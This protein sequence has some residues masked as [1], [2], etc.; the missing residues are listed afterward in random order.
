MVSVAGQAALRYGDCGQYAEDD[1]HD[2]QLDQAMPM[3]APSAS[4]RRTAA[5]YRTVQ[6][7]QPLSGAAL[8]AFR[9]NP[10]GRH[11]LRF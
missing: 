7:I 8:Q 9:R 11:F 5:T 3:M 4:G 10:F 1:D 2:H 6:S